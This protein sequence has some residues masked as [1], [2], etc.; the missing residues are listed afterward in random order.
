MSEATSTISTGPTV[1]TFN[2]VGV[3]DVD[4]E[5][6][7]LLR[8]AATKSDMTSATTSRPNLPVAE[9]RREETGL[10]RPKPKPTNVR[11]WSMSTVLRRAQLEIALLVACPPRRDRRI[12]WNGDVG[13]QPLA[14][15]RPGFDEVEELGRVVQVADTSDV[16]TRVILLAAINSRVW[17]RS[18]TEPPLEPGGLSRCNGPTTCLL[19]RVPRSV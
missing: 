5:L 9:L 1:T 12:R 8:M 4:T 6:P 17:A 14:V 18:Q 19:R 16:Q 10:N 15:D 11:G 13:T 2:A 3:R 7:P